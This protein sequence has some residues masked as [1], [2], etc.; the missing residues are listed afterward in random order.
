MQSTEGK[1]TAQ[2][3]EIKLLA[4]RAACERAYL[5]LFITRQEADAAVEKYRKELYGD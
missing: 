2:P 3:P 4:F 5:D 1:Q